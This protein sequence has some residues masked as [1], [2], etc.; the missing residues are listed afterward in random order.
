M[1]KSEFIKDKALPVFV[2]ACEWQL[3]E[4][5]KGELSRTASAAQVAAGDL[6][7][8]SFLEAVY[9]YCMPQYNS[10]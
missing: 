2:S 8:H 6:P 1:R 3:L 5:S 4:R 10:A 9:H 7:T